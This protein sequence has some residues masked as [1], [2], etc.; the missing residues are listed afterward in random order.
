MITSSDNTQLKEIR[1][2]HTKRYRGKT[3]LFLA[4]GEDLVIAAL[5]AGWQ[6]NGIYCGTGAPPDLVEHAAAHTVEDSALASCS[7]LSQ[8][9]RVLAV[10][11]QQWSEPVGNLCVYLDGAS[12]PGNV[13]TVIRSAL[14]FADGP[15][16][17]GPNCADPFSPKA[18]RASM[19][20]IFARPPARATISE[21]AG[22]HLVL[23]ANAADDL[24]SLKLSA[25]LVLCVG[26]ERDGLSEASL[27][28]ADL[29]ARIPMQANAPESINLAMAATVGLYICAGKLNILQSDMHNSAQAPSTS[30]ISPSLE[31]KE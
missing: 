27:D 26:S 9:S 12:D 20:A 30:G 17:L 10:F 31:N 29:R 5:Q 2:L 8:G 1:K 18:V 15:V 16:I 21:I 19:G 14:A 3:G 25:P 11:A 22:T 13:G 4:E 28:A 24:G 6:P 23:D 7:T